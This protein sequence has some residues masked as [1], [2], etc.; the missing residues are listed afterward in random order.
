VSAY[1]EVSVMLH[2]DDGQEIYFN[3]GDEADKCQCYF[4]ILIPDFDSWCNM[5]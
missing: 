4:I 2:R 5:I 3:K 1:V